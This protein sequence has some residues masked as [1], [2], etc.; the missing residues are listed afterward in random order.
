MFLIF[1]DDP[2]RYDQGSLNGHLS[3]LKRWCGSPDHWD[4]HEDLGDAINC[5][6]EEVVNS[7]HPLV[8]WDDVT[9]KIIYVIK[10]SQVCPGCGKNKKSNVFICTCGWERRFVCGKGQVDISPEQRNDCTCWA[11]MCIVH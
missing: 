8:V 3:Y 5:V 2:E 10:P 7:K 6:K 1:I 4:S 9:E 11:G